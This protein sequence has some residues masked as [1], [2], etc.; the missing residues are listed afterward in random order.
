MGSYPEPIVGFCLQIRH[1]LPLLVV[2]VAVVAAAVVVNS[3]NIFL[4]CSLA[5]L[6]ASP[7]LSFS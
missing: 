6:F 1:C 2:L 5:L 7:Y 3:N 4:R